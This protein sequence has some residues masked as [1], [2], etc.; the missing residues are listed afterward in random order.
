MIK[1]EVG[2]VDCFGGKHRSDACSFVYKYNVKGE[3]SLKFKEYRL[4]CQG[5]VKKK[6]LVT[7]TEGTTGLVREVE[8]EEARDGDEGRV[9]AVEEV[10]VLHEGTR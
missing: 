2:S 1:D 9:I 10:I 8:D 4:G 3:Q 5:L 6:L 7:G